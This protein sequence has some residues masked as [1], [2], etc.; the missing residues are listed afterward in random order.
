MLNKREITVK[1]GK[2]EA[3]DGEADEPKDETPIEDKVQ[4]VVRVLEKFAFKG[5]ACVCVFVALDTIR[6][7]AIAKAN[8]PDK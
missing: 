4:N 3:K 6:Q 1:I 2:K 8:K 5:F 7:I